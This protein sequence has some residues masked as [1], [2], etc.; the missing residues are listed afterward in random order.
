MP[1]GRVRGIG[2][3]SCFSTFLSS[4][5]LSLRLASPSSESLL[6]RNV[7]SSVSPLRSALSP[8]PLV[9]ARDCADAPVESLRSE[10][11]VSVGRFRLPRRLP[12]HHSPPMERSDSY[13]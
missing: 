4:T 10:G 13:E 12:I 3:S 9:E 5:S 1:T 11:S 7:S 6:L 8:V 2:L